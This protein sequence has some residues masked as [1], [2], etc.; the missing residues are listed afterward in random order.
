MTRRKWIA[1]NEERKAVRWRTYYESDGRCYWCD[2]ELSVEN[3]TVEHIT[4]LSE[5]GQRISRSNLAIA[6]R[7][8][9][10]CKKDKDYP[11]SVVNPVKAW[12]GWVYRTTNLVEASDIES[13]LL[14]ARKMD[15]RAGRGTV[16]TLMALPESPRE[17]KMR[18]RFKSVKPPRG[19]I[20]LPH[21]YKPRHLPGES[22]EFGT[23]L[24]DALRLAGITTR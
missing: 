18:A 12:F 7:H 21:G 22:S 5:G 23:R 16:I 3:F 8:C 24:G 15:V 10:G 6:C 19:A 1:D 2:I 20:E 14:L 11:R 17:A 4:P 13:I 9:N